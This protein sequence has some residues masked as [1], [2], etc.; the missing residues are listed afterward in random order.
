MRWVSMTLLTLERRLKS[1]EAQVAQLQDQLRALHAPN[2]KD[3]RRTVGAFTDDDGMKE[4][5]RDATRLRE[6]DRRKARAKKP[7]KRNPKA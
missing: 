1:L 4:T 5:L 7:A 3:W 2:Q 6:A